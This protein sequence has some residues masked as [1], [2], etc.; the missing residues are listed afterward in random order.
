MF[1]LNSNI[2]KVISLLVGAALTLT[3]VSN[4]ESAKA[5]FAPPIMATIFPSSGTVTGGDLITITG[6]NLQ[7][8]N[9]IEVGGT[10]VFRED[11]EKSPIGEWITFRAPY[12][13]KTGPA[14][15]TFLSTVNVT[16]PNF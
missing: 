6:Q 1:T 10:R 7:R 3:M 5:S 16:E 12:S 9:D 14:D 13:A 8:V 15:V 2:R 4:T 11:L